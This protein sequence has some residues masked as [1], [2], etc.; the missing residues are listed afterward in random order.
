MSRGDNFANAVNIGLVMLWGFFMMS[1]YKTLKE[2]GD[3]DLA[4]CVVGSF[5]W[6]IFWVIIHSRP[7]SEESKQLYIT[8]NCVIIIWSSAVVINVSGWTYHSFSVY[9]VS[10]YIGV[11]FFRTV[12]FILE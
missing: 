10:F 12:C 8:L 1:E 7:L 2:H 3:T 4:L 11:M 5:F 9:L 6:N